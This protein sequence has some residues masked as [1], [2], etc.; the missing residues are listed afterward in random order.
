M[1]RFAHD[2]FAKDLLK[3]LLKPLGDVQSPRSVIGEAKQIDAWFVPHPQSVSQELGLLG[4][5]ATHP[6]L[7]EPFRNSPTPTEI[8]TCLLKL[9]EVQG[10]FQRS[11]RREKQRLLEANLPKLWIITPTASVPLLN[12]FRAMVDEENWGRGVYFFSNYLRTAVI[13]IHQLP[14]TKDT[15]WLRVLGKG[16]VQK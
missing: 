14:C 13:V 9:F 1:T 15:L 4:R 10:E 8:R 16:T 2:V 7:L 5:I 3:E 11:A 12:G 6:C